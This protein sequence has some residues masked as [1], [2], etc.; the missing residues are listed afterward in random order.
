MSLLELKKQMKAKKP[1]F[2]RQD[3]HKKKRL[4]LVWRRPK[5]IDSKLRKNLKGHGFI[6]QAGYR[7][8]KAVRGMLDNGLMPALVRNVQ[9]L[10][11]LDNKTHIMIIAGSVGLKAKLQL[12][13]LAEK[14]GL[15]VANADK[16]R[17]QEKLAAKQKR[18]QEVQ[19]RAKAKTATTEKKL[20]EKVASPE[21]KKE[22]EKQEKEKLLTQRER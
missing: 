7:G 21:E 5:G 12:L 10:N 2:L 4:A 20:A 6:V 13:Q 1:E 19:E 22:L 15:K 11:S 17:L 9:E 16:T 14:K 3:Y 8:P 18:R